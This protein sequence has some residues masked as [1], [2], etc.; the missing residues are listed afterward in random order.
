MRFLLSRLPICAL[1]VVF[2]LTAT[3]LSRAQESSLPWCGLGQLNLDIGPR[4]ESPSSRGHWLV[5]EIRNRSESDCKLPPYSVGFAPNGPDFTDIFENTDY[6]D[7]S[8]AASEF[9]EKSRRLA[10]GSE[11]H[12]L[13]AWSSV[14]VEYNGI[15][16]GDCN[17]HDAMTLYSDSSHPALEV[18]HLWIQSCGQIW[19][20]SYRAGPYVSGEPVSDEWLQRVQLKDSDFTKDP[21][22]HSGRTGDVPSDG[23]KLWALLDV[24]YLK[25]SPGS[26]YYGAFPLFFKT[27]PQGSGL[28]PFRSLRK[29]EADGQTTI[30]LSHCEA[31]SEPVADNTG[32]KQ[33]GF[34]E[35]DFGL[36]PERTGGV[37]YEVVNEVLEGG[38]PTLVKAS[39]ELTIRDPSRPMLP[40]IDT[41]TPP[42][43]VSQL[44]LISP[45]VE[46]GSHWDRATIYPPLG[47]DWYDG[48]VFEV[49]NVSNQSCMLGGVPELK[50]QR[51]SSWTSGGVEPAVCR[52]CATPLF[53]PRGSLWIELQPGDS[54]HFIV[55]RAVSTYWPA[56]TATGGIDMH[57]PGDT[58][59]LRLPFEANFCGEIAASAW[60]SG[61]YDGDP[62]NLEYDR[63]EDER[64][65]EW[66]GRFPLSDSK[67]DCVDNTKPKSELPLPG[68]RCE[69]VEFAK[70]GKPVM[71]MSDGGIAYGISFPDGKPTTVYIWLDNQTDEPQ[72]YYVCCR[73]SFLNYIE[74]YDSAGQR[75]LRKGEQAGQKLCDRE[76][77]GCMCSTWV[78][79]APHTVQV[80]DS[81]DLGDGYLLSAGRY[82]VVP[83]R[84]GRKACELLN[85][86]LADGS[87]VKAANAVMIAIPEQ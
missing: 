37:E 39:L 6:K 63:R 56:C 38:K 12:V 26:G 27:S 74:V 9:K 61:K 82:F 46:L 28:C 47:E 67:V 19:R 45:V 52:N 87:K 30:Y 86:A 36:A 60:R 64:E 10:P 41:S 75:L 71:S 70:R 3:C 55:A 50:F 18:R 54:A 14:P 24:Q 66:Q 62:M 81:G 53:K 83:S 17:V 21:V 33:V 77:A 65:K 51:P 49:T 5:I 85:R 31:K 13:L 8:K 7:T 34:F 73:A 43:Q 15:L 23:A 1:I 72:H 69:E 32:S 57:L 35:T 29:R 84:S 22:T 58:Q 40:T 4:D 48:K 2:A 20:S 79:V 44:K 11:A 16:I 80:V 78:S 25:G 68:P 42:C 76:L 59:T